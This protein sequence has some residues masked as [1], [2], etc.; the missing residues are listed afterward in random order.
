MLDLNLVKQM[1]QV[2]APTNLE[3]SPTNDKDAELAF[4]YD[5]NKLQLSLKIYEGSKAENRIFAA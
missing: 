5:P 1:S 3:L 4:E 2:H